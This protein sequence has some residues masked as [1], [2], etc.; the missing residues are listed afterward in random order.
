MRLDDE[1][2]QARLLIRDRDGK[3]TRES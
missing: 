2:I 3:F 1:G